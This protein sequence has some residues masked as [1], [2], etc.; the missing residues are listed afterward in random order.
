[1]KDATNCKRN[2]ECMDVLSHCLQTTTVK[3]YNMLDPVEGL[4]D[5]V[6]RDLG[7]GADYVF[8]QIPQDLRT[9]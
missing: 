5:I 6:R 1:M 8:T 9:R 4:L 7:K 2:G 3:Y